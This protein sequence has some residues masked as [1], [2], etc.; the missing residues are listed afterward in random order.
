MSDRTNPAVGQQEITPHDTNPLDVIT[1]GIY[2]G[3]TGNIKLKG[4][5]GNDVTLYS[6]PAGLI[7]PV[8][9]EHVYSTGTTATHLVALY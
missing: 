1:R 6:C 5:D 3:G 4:L 7:L 2:V 8:E 9:T